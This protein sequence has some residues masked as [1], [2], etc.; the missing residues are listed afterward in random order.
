MIQ[1]LILTHTCGLK[2]VIM[3]MNILNGASG[4]AAQQKT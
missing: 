2:L 3:A 1:M 4:L